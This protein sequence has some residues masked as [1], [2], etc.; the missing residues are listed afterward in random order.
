MLAMALLS[1]LA[2]LGTS[3]PVVVYQ[4]LT[5]L[6]DEFDI[7]RFGASATKFDEQL[8][9]PLS[10]KYLQTLAFEAVAA[11]I[12]QLGV[13]ES[14][15]EKFR[16][17]TR[18]NISTKQDLATWWL[19]FRDGADPEIAEEDREFVN[20][21]LEI[22]PERPIDENTW[23]NW[24]R[25]VKEKTDRRGRGLFMPLR[26]ALTGQSSGPDMGAVMPLLQ[27]IKAK[28]L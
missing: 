14:L 1:L 5:E 17:T 19:I 22:L 16:L 18:G 28:A 3:D 20:V 25:D 6:V 27:V 2:R 4:N 7:S 24:T 23:A 8:L 26:K 15:A 12:K 10:G 9:F 21:A 13:P 11:E